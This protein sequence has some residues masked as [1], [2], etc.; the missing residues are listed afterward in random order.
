MNT[1]K[2]TLEGNSEVLKLGNQCLVELIT[3]CDDTYFAL[4]LT[5][6]YTINYKHWGKDIYIV[7]YKGLK[8]ASV[9]HKYMKKKGAIQFADSEIF[10]YSFQPKIGLFIYRKHLNND[11]IIYQSN[12]T[13]ALQEHSIRIGGT[14]IDLPEDR[15]LLL[16]TLGKLLFKQI[17]HEKLNVVALEEEEF[18]K[19]FNEV[20]FDLVHLS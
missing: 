18:S 2:W 11:S 15:L 16:I 7:T 10:H 13:N 19:C 20:V 4:I 5:N 14:M 6:A 3:Q 9:F 12:T 8:V 1:I 17:Q